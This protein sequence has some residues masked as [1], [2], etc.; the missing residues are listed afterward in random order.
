MFST[1]IQTTENGFSFA[2]VRA[3][4]N[5]DKNAHMRDVFTVGARFNFL[6]CNLN[7]QARAPIFRLLF[8]Y[9][10]ICSGASYLAFGLVL[11]NGPLVSNGS[12]CV[13]SNMY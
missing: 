8:G 6:R 3:L 13:I 9:Q 1:K 12:H 7:F 4:I 11:A 10:M 2:I 5:F